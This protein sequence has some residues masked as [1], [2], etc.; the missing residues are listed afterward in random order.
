M[1]NFITLFEQR[2]ES[3]AEKS[4]LFEKYKKELIN[5]FVEGRIVPEIRKEGKILRV[6][7]SDFNFF[8]DED[9]NKVKHIR[10]I[11]FEIDIS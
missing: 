6:G 7:I 3:A 9:K 10:D 8:I 2:A 1:G 4:V 11:Y 5:A